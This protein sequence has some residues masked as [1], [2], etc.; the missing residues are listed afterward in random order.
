MQRRRTEQGEGNEAQQPLLDV[1][2]EV[3]GNRGCRPGRECFRECFRRCTRGQ[4]LLSVLLLSAT[5]L[6]VVQLVYTFEIYETHEACSA[7][8]TVHFPARNP[9]ALS[10]DCKQR[11]CIVASCVPPEDFPAGDH[12]ILSL[13]AALNVT[14]GISDHSPALVCSF[15]EMLTS[16]GSFTVGA[17]TLEALSISG[18]SAVSPP[19]ATWTHATRL[20]AR[21]VVSKKAALFVAAVVFRDQVPS[22]GPGAAQV[23]G[24]FVASN[25]MFIGLVASSGGAILV[26]SDGRAHFNHCVFDSNRAEGNQYARDHQY[27]V[28]VNQWPTRD[29]Y[30][31]D[32]GSIYITSPGSVSLTD[33][34]IRR[35]TSVL[36]SSAQGPKDFNA[37]YYGSGGAIHISSYSGGAWPKYAP[38]GE[39]VITR[40]TFCSNDAP[41]FPDSSDIAASRFGWLPKENALVCPSPTQDCSYS[42]LHNNA[43]CLSG[44]HVEISFQM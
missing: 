12:R 1:A 6:C 2:M 41:V 30:P 25:S 36:K 16:A 17:T 40:T 14:P 5:A 42:S 37:D 34:M 35:S 31:S 33:T 21:F 38:G 24:T 13:D 4:R 18:K 26:E 29:Q 11:T 7:P 20:W 44:D 10:F 23:S 43:C 32:G 15:D 3:K 27:P 19:I 9:H 28:V 8:L 39:L 22:A